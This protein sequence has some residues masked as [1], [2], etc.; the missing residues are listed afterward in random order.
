MTPEPLIEDEQAEA[1]ISH[2]FFCEPDAVAERYPNIFGE[3]IVDGVFSAE[4][5]MKRAS[6]YKKS[7]ES[8]TKRA[9]DR[10]DMPEVLR[11]TREFHIAAVGHKWPPA[12]APFVFFLFFV[13]LDMPRRPNND[14]C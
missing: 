13:G 11:A 5:F 14:E 9:A 1:S 7:F 6:P 8:L 3:F 12:F 10:S 4:D 2:D